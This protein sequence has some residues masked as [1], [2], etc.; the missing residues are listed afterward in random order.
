MA[1]A[2]TSSANERRLMGD[3]IRAI[4]ADATAV[5]EQ[6][7]ADRENGEQPWRQDFFADGRTVYFEPGQGRPPAPSE[8][9][10]DVWGNR[11]CSTWGSA[12]VWDC[13]NVYL[14]E[15]AAQ[16]TIIGEGVDGAGNPVSGRFRALIAHW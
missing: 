1:F 16:T 4:H 9:R 15:D 12:G 11:Y 8:G 7:A 2:T 3:E 6:S 13:Y 14:D 10:W 5:E